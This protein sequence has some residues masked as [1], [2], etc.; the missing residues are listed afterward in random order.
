M[1]ANGM[2][3]GCIEKEPSTG[4]ERADTQFEMC[5]NRRAV[6]LKRENIVNRR[7]VIGFVVVAV[8]VALTV[9]FWFF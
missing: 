7:L 3:P 4:A 9:V 2:Q 6:R 5:Y 8:V 1:V